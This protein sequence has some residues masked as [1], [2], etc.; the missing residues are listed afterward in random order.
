VEKELSSSISSPKAKSAKQEAFEQEA[1]EKLEHPDMGA[2]DRM[3][4]KIIKPN[5]KRTP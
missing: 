4:K 1:R 2:F 5:K 3:M